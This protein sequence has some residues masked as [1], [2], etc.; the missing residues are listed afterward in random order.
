MSMGQT[1]MTSSLYCGPSRYGSFFL[2][3]FLSFALCQITLLLKGMSSSD[4]CVLTKQHPPS[5]DQHPDSVASRDDSKNVVAKE[6]MIKAQP[7]KEHR[8]KQEQIATHDPAQAVLAAGGV[9][10]PKRTPP[11]IPPRSIAGAPTPAMLRGGVS[12]GP[13]TATPEVAPPTTATSVVGPAPPAPSSTSTASTSTAPSPAEN[14]ATAWRQLT[15]NDAP[16]RFRPQSTIPHA[17]DHGR[18]CGTMRRKLQEAQLRRYRLRRGRQVGGGKDAYD[19]EVKDAYEEIV[20]AGPAATITR[21]AV[22]GCGDPG[23]SDGGVFYEVSGGVCILREGDPSA[24]HPALDFAIIPWDFSSDFSSSGEF[25]NPRVH[26]DLLNGCRA[27]WAMW[28]KSGTIRAFNLLEEEVSSLE[29][30]KGASL[31][32]HLQ[33]ENKTLT[34]ANGCPPVVDEMNGSLTPANIPPGNEKYSVSSELFTAERR[35]RILG[36]PGQTVLIY[37]STRPIITVVFMAINKV[38]RFPG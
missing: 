38:K 15:I 13:T 30:Y 22:K 17:T 21:W 19:E 4:H 9:D 34:L 1:Y 32:T 12:G 26:R 36:F 10:S 2:A 29:D 5:Q 6:H 8:A 24:L 16:L 14:G 23:D 31:R 20:G 33:T 27:D 11:E 25:G 37:P 3:L 18:G 7:A 35:E 28:L